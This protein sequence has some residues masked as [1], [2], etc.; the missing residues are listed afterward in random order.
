MCGLTGYISFNEKNHG[1]KKLITE[2]TKELNHRGPDS[3]GIKNIYT[4]NGINVA[5]GH[6]RLSIL[7][8]SERGNQPFIYKDFII[9]YNGEIYNF[10]DI[11]KELISLGHCFETEC[12]T[13]VIAHSFDQ[14]KDKCFEKFIGMFSLVIYEKK[15]EKIFFISDRVGTKPLYYYVDKE[16]IIFSSELK[17]LHKH[18]L[19][20]KEVDIGSLKLYLNLGYI[21][22]PHSI[23]ENCKKLSPATILE[24][25]LKNNNFKSKNYWNL[26][27]HYEKDK[28]DLS[29]HDSLQKLEKILKSSFDLRMISDV[30]VGV[31]LSGG[32]DSTSV[33][34]IIT[35]SLNS[36]L[37]TFTIGTDDKLNEA[38]NAK[39]IADFFNTNHKEL[40]CN[41]NEAKNII[42][43]LAFIY[44][45]PFADISAIPTILVSRLAKKDVTV[46][47]S[48]DGGDEIFA[49]YNI[50]RTFIKNLNQILFFRKYFKIP[51]IYLSNLLLRIL[52]DSSYL[53]YK[54]GIL[55]TCL[56]CSTVEVRN[57]LFKSYFF[58]NKKLI[59]K[60]VIGI[61]PMHK[62][63][64]DDLNF[65]IKDDLDY[66]Q[67][68]DYTTYLSGNIMTKV[69]R[70]SMST[71]LEGREPMLDHRIIEFLANLP[72]SYKFTK[73]IQK[74]ILKDIVHRYIPRELVDRPKTGFV[75][76]IYDWLKKDLKSLIDKYLSEESI[77]QYGFFN[78]KLIEN[79]KKDFTNNSLNDKSIIWKVLQLQIWASKWIEK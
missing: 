36:K 67:H 8:L 32:Y 68:I 62:T 16:I 11:R 5:F 57:I 23:F 65:E 77:N 34:S 39:K 43:E 51:M 52:K 29:Y 3:Y 1:T 64:F 10:I 78:Y 54:I 20:K 13:E 50:Y 66:V 61:K 31:F 74:K 21:P 7:D 76:P 55:N 49:G 79:I 6:T 9:V 75:I 35:N 60:M 69:D 17:S 40:Y 63:K 73:N 38:V 26:K 44:D 45:E 48:A 24:L 18:P 28:S 37:N 42:E 58:K 4:P 22:H 30:P 25:N 70:A 59:D 12:D 53:H 41:S 14:W 72:R 27:E 33:V 15:S 47:L 71:S 56:K 19:F 2:M 46:S